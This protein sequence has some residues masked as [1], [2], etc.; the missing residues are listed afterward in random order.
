MHFTVWSNELY[1]V[2]LTFPQ[3]GRQSGL[4]ITRHTHTF[5]PSVREWEIHSLLHT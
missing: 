1:Q 3:K 5:G 2:R 4:N